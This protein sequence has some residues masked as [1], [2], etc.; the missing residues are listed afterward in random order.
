[1][2]KFRDAIH[3]EGKRLSPESLGAIDR[4]P[5]A[6]AVDA[7]ID[8]V[9]RTGQRLVESAIPQALSQGLPSWTALGIDSERWI[10]FPSLV[11]TRVGQTL[12]RLYFADPDP[13][14][15]TENSRALM[16]P[17]DNIW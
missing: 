5:K 8:C 4:V 16:T 7:Q 11:E 2:G 17:L 3:C 15:R 10:S 13:N 9:T 6:T 12:S 14:A 1:L